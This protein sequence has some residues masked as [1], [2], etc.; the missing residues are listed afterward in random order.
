MD[1]VF[2]GIQ[3]GNPAAGEFSS[4]EYN[5][6]VTCRVE[7]SVRTRRRAAFAIIGGKHGTVFEISIL[8]LGLVS[9]YF[10]QGRLDKNSGKKETMKRNDVGLGLVILYMN[11]GPGGISQ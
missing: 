9:A 10:V 4:Y 7:M 2:D 6:K 5:P 11:A 3:Q 1:N 8:P